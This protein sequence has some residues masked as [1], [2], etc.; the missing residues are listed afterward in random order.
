MAR[1]TEAGIMARRIEAG[2]IKV[3]LLFLVLELYTTMND[4]LTIQQ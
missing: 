1:G 2:I 4:T 3:L